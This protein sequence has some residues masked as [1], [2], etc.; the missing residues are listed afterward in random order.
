MCIRDSIYASRD[1][2][3]RTPITIGQK[4]GA[5]CASFENFAYLNLGYHHYSELGPGE[6]DF[7]TPEGVECLSAPRKEMKMC[8]FLWAYYG[9]PTASYEGISAVSY[10]H[11]DVYKRQPH[12]YP[13]ETGSWMPSA[14]R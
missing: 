8:A 9:Y 13:W 7:I 5:F 12:R 10:T 4:D 11:L 6:I 3:G 1:R 2:Y 14:L